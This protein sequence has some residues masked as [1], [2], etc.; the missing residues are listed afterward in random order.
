MDYLLLIFVLSA[1][2]VCFFSSELSELLSVFM[3]GSIS[4]NRFFIILCFALMLVCALFF[5]SARVESGAASLI[6]G[7]DSVYEI[8]ISCL[9][10]LI[11]ILSSAH[12]G[13]R[14]GF[15]Y[16][17]LSSCL[18]LNAASLLS[19]SLPGF[20]ATII[21]SAVLS[22]SLGALAAFLLKITL[23]GRGIH[24]LKLSLFAR[25]SLWFLMPLCALALG[26]NWGGL[27]SSLELNSAL[28]GT[29]SR[30]I[31]VSVA[32]L[33]AAILGRTIMRKASRSSAQWDDNSAYCTLSVAFA[34]ALTLILLSFI[35]LP[36][37][38]ITLPLAVASLIAASREGAALVLGEGHSSQSVLR[39]VYAFLLCPLASYLLTFLTRIQGPYA[40]ASQATSYTILAIV[41][42]AFAAL[43]LVYF[44]RSS[45]LQKRRTEQL[46]ESQRQQ[47]YESARELNNMEL[48][49]ILAENQALHD[50]LEKKK[51]EVM[52]I[53]LSI[54]EQR[55]YLE[56]LQRLCRELSESEDAATTKELLSELD[57][58][59]KNRLSYERD[60]DTSYFYAQAE[61]LHEDF[62]AKLTEAFP[63]LTPQ[64][65][66]LATLLRLGF[67]SKYIATLMNITPKSVEISRYRLRQKLGLGKGDNL[68][69]YIQSI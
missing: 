3:P 56:S 31:A 57:A 68:V 59:I 65:R 23:K 15:A 4:R 14:P 13:V 40:A 43:C 24:L 67:S 47:I 45:R 58:N 41:A 7:T 12:F 22:F 54:C 44:T 10:S 37:P 69:T 21:A 63:S 20:F 62:N 49:L 51:N 19:S 50:N 2:S 52:N 38:L 53:A 64:E 42:I 8:L 29:T 9:I 30:I 25:A 28:D 27:V 11:V 16:C 26:V 48:N 35:P 17:F 34:V 55:D 36:A 46:L 39:G 18:A 61:S 60:V 66:R 33:S 32:L 1:A 5:P 6:E